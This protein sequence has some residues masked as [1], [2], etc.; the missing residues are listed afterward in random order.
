MVNYALFF[1]GLPGGHFVQVRIEGLQGASDLTTAPQNITN[2]VQQFMNPDPA[3]PAKA[4]AAALN[5]KYKPKVHGLN[6]K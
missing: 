5:E 2:A 1:N 3:A 4:N 6:P